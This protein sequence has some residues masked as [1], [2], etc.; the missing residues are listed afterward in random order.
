M[1]E[2]DPRF[3]ALP[4]LQHS[5]GGTPG[6]LSNSAADL[7]TAREPYG[8]CEHT[9][10]S[11]GFSIATMMRAASMSLSHVFPRLMMWIHSQIP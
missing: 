6:E 4:E 3:G 7:S 1:L 10:M 8:R 2:E 5:T 11:F 9:M